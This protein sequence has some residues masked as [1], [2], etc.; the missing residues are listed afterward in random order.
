MQVLIRWVQTKVREGLRPY[1]WYRMWRYARV[2]RG[3]VCIDLRGI[4]RK[5]AV[6]LFGGGFQVEE[7]V[8]QLDIYE[9]CVC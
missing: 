7:N 2:N 6:D 9:V 5:E 8:R 1:G 4:V 3:R